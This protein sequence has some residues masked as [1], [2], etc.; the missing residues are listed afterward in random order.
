MCQSFKKREKNYFKKLDTKNTC[1]N[2][3]FWKTARPLLSNKSR[4]PVNVT[5]VKK[6][7][8][9]SDNDKVGDVFNDCFTSI[10][11]N[12]NITVSEDFLCQ[13]NNIKDPAL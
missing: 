1:D 12:L 10:V 9:I 7:H 8:V 11:K 4:L 13:V 5:L 6:N 2:K 3:T